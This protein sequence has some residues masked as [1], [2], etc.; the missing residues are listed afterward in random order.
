MS[1]L[2]SSTLLAQNVVV[3]FPFHLWNFFF[4]F[5]VLFLF[6]MMTASY[7]KLDSSRALPFY[8][9]ISSPPFT[10]GNLNWVDSTFEWIGPVCLCAPFSTT[11]VITND[12][13]VK[14][15]RHPIVERDDH[16]SSFIRRRKFFVLF[17][18]GEGHLLLYNYLARWLE[19]IMNKYVLYCFDLNRFVCVSCNQVVAYPWWMRII[20]NT[21]HKEICK[22]WKWSWWG[23]MSNSPGYALP[24]FVFS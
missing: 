5:F 8:S 23:M 15:V 17:V 18:G 20:T 2:S 22:I 16:S 6:E 4:C 21:T 19:F 9:S 13:L 10:A 14:Y 3:N 7:S 1:L 12:E 11:Q 24:V